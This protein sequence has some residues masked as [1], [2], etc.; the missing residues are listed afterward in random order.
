MICILHRLTATIQIKVTIIKK[1]SNLKN[2]GTIE[3][4]FWIKRTG[5][6]LYVLLSAGLLVIYGR[7]INNN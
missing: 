3:H 1:F 6:F 4:K 5:R 2:H 7:K